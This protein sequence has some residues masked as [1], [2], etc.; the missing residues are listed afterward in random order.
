MQPTILLRYRKTYDLDLILSLLILD[1]TPRW[2]VQW[3]SKHV[4]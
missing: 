2:L 1:L 3:S 4:K